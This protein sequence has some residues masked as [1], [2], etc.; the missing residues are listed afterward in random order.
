V[1]ELS[2]YGGRSMVPNEADEETRRKINKMIESIHGA[3]LRRIFDFT[4][5]IFS[6]G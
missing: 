2:T 5:R 6:K 3:L 4:Y 1:Q